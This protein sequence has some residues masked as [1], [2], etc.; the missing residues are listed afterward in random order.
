GLNYLEVLKQTGTDA[1]TNIEDG[2]KTVYTISGIDLLI[3]GTRKGTVDSKGR[4]L[5]Q[6]NLTGYKETTY[7][8]DGKG[9]IT[10]LTIQPWED[11][12]ISTNI[13]TH[14]NKNGIFRHVSTPGW[15]LVLEFSKLPS[16]FNNFTG[17][18]DQS[19]KNLLFSYTN[20]YN[21]NDYPVEVFVHPEGV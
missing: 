5:F 11:D 14:D 13:F 16:L 10:S 4:L 20:T 15:Y 9:N 3:D 1:E 2:V 19:G 18:Y 12:R 8:Y 21:S 7:T 17:E 6:D